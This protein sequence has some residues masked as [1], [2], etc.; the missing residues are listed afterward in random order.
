MRH[1]YIFGGPDRS[2][3]TT[4]AK[5]LS[6]LTGA[7]YY[8][9]ANQRQFWTE[10]R[11]NFKLLL[12]YHGPSMIDFLENVGLPGGL[13]FDRFTPCEFAYSRAYGRETNRDVIF[14][15][16]KRLA[17]MGY[18]F[19]YCWKDDYV[20]WDDDLIEES[21]I[22]K[23][24]S[25]YDAYASKSKMHTIFLNTTDQKLDTQLLQIMKGRLD[26][27]DSLRYPAINPQ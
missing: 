8:K 19:V 17:A 12:E 25:G 1:N 15:I 26:Y 10:E 6:Q 3:K 5:A 24:M 23:L 11:D 7:Q 18:V 14:N 2:G 22:G 20:D 27:E 16:D 9:A 4:I 21:M 13:I